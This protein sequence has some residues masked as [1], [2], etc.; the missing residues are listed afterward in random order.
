MLESLPELLENVKKIKSKL[1]IYCSSKD[2]KTIQMAKHSSNKKKYNL[3]FL[4]NKKIK[5]I[6]TAKKLYY[7]FIYKELV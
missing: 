4:S 5:K 2:L 1:K 6:D 3:T 7:S